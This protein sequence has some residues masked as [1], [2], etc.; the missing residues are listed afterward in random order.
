[1]KLINTPN[2]NAKKIELDSSVLSDDNFL[3]QQDKLLSDLEKL[4]GVSS[5]FFWPKFYYNYKRGQ[6]RL[7]SNKSRYY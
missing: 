1:M 3:S 2:P 5:V 6:C 7:G 4:D